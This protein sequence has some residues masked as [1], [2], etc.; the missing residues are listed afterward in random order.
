MFQYRTI[1]I[2][3]LT[4]VIMWS[5]SVVSSRRL[6]PELFRDQGGSREHSRAHGRGGTQ[7]GTRSNFESHYLPF[8]C[9]HLVAVM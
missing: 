4:A 1:Q 2:S 7:A 8:Q 3:Q 9:S 5:R 6:K